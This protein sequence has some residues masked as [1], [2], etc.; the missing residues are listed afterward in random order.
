MGTAGSHTL[1]CSH[2]VW[3][4][5]SSVDNSFARSRTHCLSTWVVVACLIRLS[6][7]FMGLHWKISNRCYAIDNDF[8]HVHSHQFNNGLLQPSW[9]LIQCG[10]TLCTRG[11]TSSSCSTPRTRELLARAWPVFQKKTFQF[12]RRRVYP[13]SSQWFSCGKNLCLCGSGHH[14]V[15]EALSDI[16]FQAED[17]RNGDLN[18]M[19]A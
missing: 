3:S 16:A 7:L 11:R 1:L 5:L 17:L 13:C 4:N 18:W 8:L 14:H 12:R 6:W 2:L 10:A 9:A 19:R 15:F